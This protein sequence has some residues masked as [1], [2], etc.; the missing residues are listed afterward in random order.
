MTDTNPRP[1][2]ARA[3]EAADEMLA[4][5]VA[6]GS[7]SPEAAL[8]MRALGF[9]TTTRILSD[10]RVRD[11]M[12]EQ[13]ITDA[14]QARLDKAEDDGDPQRAI[15]AEFALAVWDGM[16][17]DLANYLSSAGTEQR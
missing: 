4:R 5:R 17:R 11:G 7:L 1:V 8:D 3:Y 2:L 16:R 14:F 15:A 10:L 6:D 9:T 13:A 12:S